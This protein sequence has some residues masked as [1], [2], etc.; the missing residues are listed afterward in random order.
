M[1]RYSV[2][3]RPIKPPSAAAKTAHLRQHLP[4]R[5]PCQPHGPVP[6]IELRL[7]VKPIQH[8][9]TWVSGRSKGAMGSPTSLIIHPQP[10]PKLP[11]HPGRHPGGPYS[12]HRS[13]L[14]PTFTEGGCRP[15]LHGGG[16]AQRQFAA[17][18]PTSYLLGP[19]AP[20]RTPSPTRAH[21]P[22]PNRPLPLIARCVSPGFF[23]G[24]DPGAIGPP[25]ASQQIPLARPAANLFEASGLA[26]KMPA[27]IYPALRTPVSAR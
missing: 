18:G 10:T 15:S 14:S 24:G 22:P 5:A 23:P 17:F 7:N 19:P 9:A 26:P 20:G 25:M 11:C 8:E 6:R 3:A 12:H 27:A 4:G 13:H 16:R 2:L 21:A 1:K